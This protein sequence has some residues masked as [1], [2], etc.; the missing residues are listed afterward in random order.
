VIKKK[1]PEERKKMELI[2]HKHEESH[3]G[4]YLLFIAMFR[5]GW[6]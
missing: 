5:E 3:V 2:K 1:K 4:P 6:F